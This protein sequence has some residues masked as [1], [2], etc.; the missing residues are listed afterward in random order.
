MEPRSLISSGHQKQ[1]SR[2]GCMCPPDV[3]GQ[4]GCGHTR[5]WVWLPVQLAIHL[6]L[7]ATNV[8]VVKTPAVGTLWHLQYAGMIPTWY[9]PGPE[10]V[11]QNKTAKMAATSVLSPQADA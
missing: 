7:T 5:K 3:T 6:A 4:N 11:Q 9:P 2:V 8:L 10:S 1:V